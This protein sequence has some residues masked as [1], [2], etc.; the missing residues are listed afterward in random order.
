LIDV[1]KNMDDSTLMVTLVHSTNSSGQ[2]TVKSGWLW[3][4]TRDVLVKSDLNVGSL[5][6]RIS[7]SEC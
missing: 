7:S 4:V 5:N 1:R 3:K 2:M 6:N